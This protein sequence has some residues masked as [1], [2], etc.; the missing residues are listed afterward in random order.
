MSLHPFPPARRNA[1][2]GTSDVAAVEIAPHTPTM[3]DRILAFIR[4][5]GAH[6]ATDDEAEAALGIKPQSY[7]PRRGELVKLGLIRDT[8]ERRPTSSGK[9]AA[10]YVDAAL[11]DARSIPAMLPFSGLK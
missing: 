5:R 7:T 1:P 11:A 2:A 6:G 9:P 10:V 4:S 8:G 3:R